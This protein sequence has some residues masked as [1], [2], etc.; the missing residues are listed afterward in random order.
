MKDLP[1]TNQISM[2]GNDFSYDDN[3]PEIDEFDKE[4]LLALEKSTLGVYVSGHPLDDYKK[5]LLST[6]ATPVAEL[7]GTE[8]NDGTMVKIAGIVTD[9]VRKST[10]NDKEMA[11]VTIEDLTASIEVIV[12]SR[13]YSQFFN[14]LKKE[15]IVEIAGKIDNKEEQQPKIILSEAYLVNTKEQR[16]LFIKI[17]EGYEEKVNTL[18]E[19]CK[20]YSGDADIILYFEKDKSTMSGGRSLK[21]MPSEVLYGK[22][23][24]LFDNKCEIVLK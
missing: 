17:P 18:K 8:Q 23:R 24:E 12:F 2:F 5:V 16:R 7:L 15:K 4:T 1:E 14:V 21:V 3:L 9:V 10:K 6:G 20:I 22:I 19:Y 13:Q 11:F